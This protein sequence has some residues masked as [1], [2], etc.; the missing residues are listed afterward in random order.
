MQSEAGG[1][2]VPKGALNSI[3]NEEFAVLHTEIIA[4]LRGGAIWTNLYKTMRRRATSRTWEL[5][6]LL[7]VLC[8]QYAAR[9]RIPVSP[10]L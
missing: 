10:P 3:V 8:F 6:D 5:V 4:L 2:H 1:A 7:E 9:V